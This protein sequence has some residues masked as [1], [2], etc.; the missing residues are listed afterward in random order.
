MRNNA[1]YKQWI[2]TLF[3]GI[4]VLSCNKEPEETGPYLPAGVTA[5]SDDQVATVPYNGGDQLFKKAPD[6]STELLLTFIERQPTKQFY[7]W[8]Q[9]YFQLGT[10]PYLNVEA[11]LRYLQAGN[12][13]YKTLALY[14]PY[15]DD[16]GVI[17]STIFE[18]PIE[19]TS[20]TATFFEDLVIFH[21]E[22]D[23]GPLTWTN[24]YEIAPLTS[25]P[26]G[27]ES[28]EDFDRLF[29]TK[30]KG[31]IGFHQ[32]NGDQWVLFP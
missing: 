6:F 12:E 28:S 13:N 8:D 2:I 4:V 22:L 17:Q 18:F 27:E 11:R 25:T 26:I 10:D 7:A 30:E 15:W 23:L 24:V 3:L 9:T 20:Y 1:T 21:S 5:Y 16:A 29:Y 31:I 32:T 19:L 14:M